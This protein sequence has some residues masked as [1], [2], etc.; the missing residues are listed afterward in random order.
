[1]SDWDT[2]SVSNMQY[3]F[4]GASAFNADISAWNTSSVTSMSSMFFHAYS[5]NQ[6]IS[7]WDTSSVLDGKL[8]V[9]EKQ[10][11]VST[12]LSAVVIAVITYKVWEIT[13][14]DNFGMNLV[15]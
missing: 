10:V 15:N 11:S 14:R 12:F 5:F 3:M 2:S 7:K 8:P 1:M 4:Y 6:D 9:T 13:T